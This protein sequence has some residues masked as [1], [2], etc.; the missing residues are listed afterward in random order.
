MFTT[1]FRA[2]LISD[3]Y[4][5]YLGAGDCVLDV[6]CGNG[7]VDKVLKERLKIK[8]IGTDIK[9]YRL[10]KFEFKTMVRPDKLPFSDNEFTWILFNDVL[11]HSE[12]ILELLREGLRV[13]KRLLIFEMQPS[14]AAGIADVALNFFHDK[15]MPVPLNFLK[16]SEWENLLGQ[17]DCVFEIKPVRKPFWGY[18]LQH[19]FI[20]VKTRL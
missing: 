3:L 7:I 8:I 1:K 9:D 15:G 13:G 11:H 18:P 2:K 19:I 14:L 12:N 4:G 10:E 6:G 17:L 16:I 5:N 20:L